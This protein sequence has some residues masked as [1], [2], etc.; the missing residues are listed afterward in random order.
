V[1]PSDVDVYVI[2]DEPRLLAATAGVLLEEGFTVRAFGRAESAL[3]WIELERP[4]LVITDEQMPGMA[5][6]ELMEWAREHLRNRAPRF[7]L[8][9]G[10]DVP[11]SILAGFD[12]VLYKPF[13]LE[14][15]LSCARRFGQRRAMK[16]G[17]QLRG[18]LLE[19]REEKK[20]SG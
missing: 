10:A 2:E 3:Q 14:D 18:D 4:R 12:A 8:V 17:T 19:Q 13:R 6:H 11:K 9:T 1:K 16:S 15:L 7:V 20:Q 5:G